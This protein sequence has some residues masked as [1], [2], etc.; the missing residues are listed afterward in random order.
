MRKLILVILL[1]ILVVGTFFFYVAKE[2]DDQNENEIVENVIENTTENVI[3][4]TLDEV[5]N[6][7]PENIIEN[8][9]DEKVVETN[10]KVILEV[11]GNS[12]EVTLENNS[13]S[14]ELYEKIKNEGLTLRVRDYGGFE[15]VGALGFP[16]T[17]ED[18]EIETY[19]G[20]LVLYN[21]S[22]LSI[23]YKPHS[24]SYTKLGH[25]DIENVEAFLGKGEVELKFRT[26]ESEIKT[27][28]EE[29]IEN[30]VD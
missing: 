19:P 1:I 21:G 20:D 2:K 11:N 6:I 12:V 29:T 22:Q 9:V 28:I 27:D 10:K 26:V 13:A 3:E 25:F 16:L 18:K 5:E 24:W 8:K 14:N 30:V 17:R 7:L 15:K 23:F 4:N